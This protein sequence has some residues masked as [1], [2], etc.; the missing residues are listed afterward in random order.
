[1]F[2]WTQEIETLAIELLQELIQIDTSNPPG[3]EIDAAKYI[4]EVLAR[5]GIES[6]IIE[7]NPGRGNLAAKIP[8]GDDDPLVLLSH[9]D[10]APAEGEWDIPPFSGK[11]HQGFIWGR[12]AL[13]TKQLTTMQLISLIM[14]KRSGQS[15]RRDIF[16]LATA[17]EEAG[18]IWG[19]EA[20]V[21]NGKIRIPPG[22]CL[23]EGGGF[24]L[25]I[26]GKEFL[27]ITTGEKGKAL[28][29]IKSEGPGGHSSCPQPNQAIFKFA[30]A[31]EGLIQKEFPVE[32][33]VTEKEF[34]KL[35]GNY[36][37]GASKELLNYMQ[38]IGIIVKNIRGG[39]TANVIPAEIEGEIELRFP[40]TIKRDKLESGLKEIFAGQD[41]GWEI[42][43]FE[44]GFQSPPGNQFFKILSRITAEYNPDLKLLPILA[45]GR[46]DGRFLGPDGTSVYGF[47]PTNEETPWEEVLKQVHQ[48]N[49]R[50]SID[51]FMQGTKILAQSVLEYCI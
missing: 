31:L 19:M 30:R 26:E 6:N 38:K 12:G 32:E 33:T 1:M 36:S 14:L 23:N 37:S 21:K 45:L 13:D 3:R 51:S 4:K 42:T 18:S 29:K 7:T 47:A 49:E 11:K 41:V 40:P 16:L 8:G 17:D 39:K 25:S 46:T 10:V 44:D 43:E 28:L 35:L 50:I 20:L 15:P 2:N 24:Y 5:E 9:L 27:L 34:K 22:V 48:K